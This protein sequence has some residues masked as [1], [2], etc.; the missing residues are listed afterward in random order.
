M[1]P[2][3]P[4]GI[5]QGINAYLRPRFTSITSAY[6]VNSGSSSGS[7]GKIGLTR[8]NTTAGPQ[9][10]RR[11][12]ARFNSFQSFDALPTL[13]GP[14][15]ALAAARKAQ[16]HRERSWGPV[17]ASAGGFSFPSSMNNGSRDLQPETA[18]DEEEEDEP[19]WGLGRHM[20]LFE[21]SS[22]DASG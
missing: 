10:P 11:E 5:G 7:S 20:Q 15:R 6:T 19:E 14:Q 1:R 12:G 17:S 9:S 4:T 18:S 2:H 3:T 8:A 21:V 22:K 16:H 13:A